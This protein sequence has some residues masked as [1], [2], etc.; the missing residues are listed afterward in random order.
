M[1]QNTRGADQQG[2]CFMTGATR[3]PKGRSPVVAAQRP[4]AQAPQR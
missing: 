4:K 2:S 1:I 3:R